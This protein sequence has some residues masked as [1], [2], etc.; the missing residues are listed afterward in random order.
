METS[1]PQW[2]SSDYI[3]MELTHLSSE[4][5][6]VKIRNNNDSTKNKNQ[7]YKNIGYR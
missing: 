7:N 4:K 2:V 6:F 1:E 5:Q 3:N